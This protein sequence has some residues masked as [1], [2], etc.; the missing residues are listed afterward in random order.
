MIPDPYRVL[1]VSPNASD[2]EV[3]KAY[4]KLAMK[5]HPD[6][7]PGDKNAEQKM[8]EINAAYDQIVN[9]DKY[10]QSRR[11]P[12]AGYGGSPYG[13][14]GSA[15]GGG[16]YRQNPY[17]HNPYGQG[18]GSGD[19]FAGWGWGWPFG[20]YSSTETDTPEMAAVRQKL[21]RKDFQGALGD[22]NRIGNRTARWYYYSAMAYSGM[23]NSAAALNNAQR[24]ASMD[25]F[26][27]EYRMY[28]EQLS[29]RGTQTQ[30]PQTQN[31]GCAF[32][33]AVKIFVI[34]IIVNIVLNFILMLAGGTGGVFVGGI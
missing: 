9:R 14:A 19:P 2:D 12:Y 31:T 13:G 4:R 20:G 11:G 27:I 1:G 22:L 24:A 28:L 10:A 34:I 15:T 16:A 5:Y 30:R 3:K 32:D 8:K 29:G 23:G 33:T 7:N 18:Q 25:P 26:N 17:G 21:E 6:S